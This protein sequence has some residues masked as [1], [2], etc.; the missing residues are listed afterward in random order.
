MSSVFELID[1]G[2]A[3][4]LRA[5]L[6]REPQAAAER[7]AAGL[8]VVMR[9]AYRG[10]AVYD[11]VLAA[12]PPLDPFDRIMVG[13]SDEL[14]APDALTPDGFTGL[15]IAAFASNAPAAAALLAAGA[16]P[17]VV[18]TASFALVTPLGTCAFSRAT[19][20]ARILLEH[21]AD[22]NLTGEAGGGTPL[23]SA[24]QNGNEE[25]VELLVTHG[26]TR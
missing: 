3:D 13:R 21:G 18:A 12:D 20:V 1:A 26:A 11:A 25:L 23:R 6:E 10:G 4:G 8:S 2:D 16:D 19:E 24:E 7:D 9:A 17:N 22:P 14:P 15:H 5:L